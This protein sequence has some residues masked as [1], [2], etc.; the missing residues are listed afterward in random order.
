MSASYVSVRAHVRLLIACL[1]PAT[2]RVHH[3][4]AS[5]TGCMCVHPQEELLFVWLLLIAAVVAS[6]LILQYKLTLVTPSAAALCLGIVAGI[7]ANVAGAPAP[8]AERALRPPLRGRSGAGAGP[9]PPAAGERGAPPLTPARPVAGMS[10][11]LRFSPTAFFYGLLPPIVFAA[12]A[13]GGPPTPSRPAPR[14]GSLTAAHAPALACCLGAAGSSCLTGACCCCPAA[15]PPPRAA[16][17]PPDSS[18]GSGGFGNP[19]AGFVLQQKDFFKNAPAGWGQGGCTN[20]SPIAGFTLKKKNFFKNAP[21]IALFAV[22]GT[23]ISTLVFGLLTYFLL[24]IRVVRRSALGPA[25]LTECMLYG[26]ARL[27]RGRGGRPAS[28]Q[29]CMHVPVPLAK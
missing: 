23:L 3:A 27:A 25:P 7:G 18:A 11:T 4:A 17:P 8:A 20:P 13:L 5:L 16:R 9:G 29:L 2:V 22:A 26:A 12:G 19:V 14:H 6:F 28:A 21:A 1:G 24:A 10:S 15:P